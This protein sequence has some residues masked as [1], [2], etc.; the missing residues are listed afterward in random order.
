MTIN[1]KSITPVVLVKLNGDVYD[2]AG[3]LGLLNFQNI[4]PVVLVKEDGTPY[5]ADSGGGG[6][7]Y[8]DE[9]AQDAVGGILADTA[10]INLTYTDATPA[11]TADVIDGSITTAKLS[12]DPATQAELDA[13]ISD[14]SD[15]HD[16][17]TISV[18]STT[19]AG[20]GTDVQAVLEE[21]D[22]AI[23]AA[24]GTPGGANTQ[25]QFNDSGVFGGDAGLTY[26]KTNDSLII[27]GTAYNEI[28]KDALTIHNTVFSASV[29][30]GLH[31]GQYDDGGVFLSS[32]NYLTYF[33]LD[34]GGENYLQGGLEVNSGRFI[35][36]LEINNAISA[37]GV[38]LSL[39]D[40]L[41]TSNDLTPTDELY[42]TLVQTVY[43]GG[44]AA[45]KATLNNF[46]STVV[47]QGV[48]DADSE[49][50]GHINFIRS[51]IGTGYTQTTGPTGRA[52]LGDWAV[53]GPIAVQ[54]NTLNGLTLVVNNNY[55]GNPA[56]SPSGGIWILTE[57]GKGA[58]IDATHA[59]ANTY[60]VQVGLGITGRSNVAATPGVG[61][62]TGI[63]I[64][65][66]GS[67]WDETASI[68]GT[69]IHIRDYTT[70]GIKIDNASGSPTASIETDGNIIVGGLTASRPVIADSGKKLTVGTYSG[71][72][73]QLATV[74][75]TKTTSKQLAF[76][77]DGNVIASASDIGGSS[78]PVMA[79][80]THSTSQTV[81]GATN[82]AV[83]LDTEVQDT[84]TLH[85]TSTNNSRITNNTGSTKTCTISATAQLTFG[86]HSV[87]VIS[88]IALLLNGTT[89]LDAQM[90]PPV[91]TQAY[92][93]NVSAVR[94]LANNDYIE[95]QVRN[96]TDA[97][98]TV[99]QG[100]E[101]TPILSVV[102][103]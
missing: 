28:T 53:H 37:T 16:A 17:S 86:T 61:F 99:A 97:T 40:L 12:F 26:N 5:E 72:T 85:D 66:S 56:D 35:N 3:T 42:N 13:H 20:T 88:G 23:A 91:A 57:K 98:L 50:G 24:T 22:N 89:I 6:G 7:S 95:L 44:G 60:P 43:G 90:M 87:P 4:T 32:G 75:G 38:K 93:L 79:R 51:D 31:L 96:S 2:I 80:V 25:V 92:I 9:Q 94:Q 65:G 73:T 21:L 103:M 48:G 74:T 34:A 68:V 46:S 18:D 83:A 84:A 102:M 101:Y 8:T 15:A 14:T 76:D 33:S 45:T 62:T 36:N 1:Y 63:Q 54:P 39:F 70:H 81:A 55:N 69:G 67:P 64:G 41:I 58:G 27:K 10:T 52:W 82:Q 71:N 11:I 78:S 47:V 100:T 30:D 59:A 29:A 49:F 77:S 19:L